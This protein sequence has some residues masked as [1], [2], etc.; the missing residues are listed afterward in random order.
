MKL[1]ELNIKRIK[2]LCRLHKVKTLFVFGSILTDR[3]N[4]SSDVDLLVDFNGEIDYNNYAD[5]FFSLYHALCDL[6]NREVDLV[7]AAALSN[8]FFINE[9]EQ[10]KKLIYG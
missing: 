7:D 10:T 3:F 9:V 1:I 5:N 8:P 4:E 6:F 2:E